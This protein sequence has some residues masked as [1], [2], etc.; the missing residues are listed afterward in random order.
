VLIRLDAF[1]MTQPHRRDLGQW[2][3]HW[4]KRDG[5]SEA[6]DVLAQI[7]SERKIRASSRH[8]RGGAECVCFTETP[9]QEVSAY[10]APTLS[11][12]PP[13][14]EP[15]G[16]A[17]RKDWL[18]ERGG[19]PVIYQSNSEFEALPKHLQWRHCRYEPGSVDFTW[20]REWRI[21]SDVALDP[22]H[23]I[24]VAPTYEETA[25]LLLLS[26][27]VEVI[28]L[29]DESTPDLAPVYVWKVVSLELL[30]AKGW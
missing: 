3:F 4:T 5:E 13:R 28:G 1:D 15:Y 29:I 16:I 18:F 26:P 30:L 10:F 20:E 2:L 22:A 21:Q 11:A 14:Y 9:V 19:R 27:D 25:E 17:V 23:T 24:V 8:I 6:Y 7:L 12:E